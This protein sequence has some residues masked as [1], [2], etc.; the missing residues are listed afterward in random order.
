MNILEKARLDTELESLA[1]WAHLN[2]AIEKTWAFAD[3]KEALAFIV[4][5]GILAEL[6]NHHPEIKNVYNRVV[7]RLNTHEVGAI[8]DKDIDL[9]RQINTI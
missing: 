3:F 6:A 7:L 2:E 4:K 5:V 8:T 9:A 1:G